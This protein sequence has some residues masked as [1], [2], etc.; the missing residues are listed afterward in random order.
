LTL[1]YARRHVDP[2]VQNIIQLQGGVLKWI[3]L[4]AFS[5]GSVD[6]DIRVY[7]ESIFGLDILGSSD[8]FATVQDYLDAFQKGE[9]LKFLRVCIQKVYELCKK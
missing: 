3:D 9:S 7:F 8:M 5:A 2:Q 6:D 4:R 1:F